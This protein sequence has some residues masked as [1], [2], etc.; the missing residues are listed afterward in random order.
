[1]A[2]L[3]AV[4]KNT[5][6]TAKADRTPNPFKPAFTRT[7]VEDEPTVKADPDEHERFKVQGSTLHSMSRKRLKALEGRTLYS[8]FAPTDAAMRLQRA[9]KMRHTVK[10]WRR[11]PAER[12]EW[13]PRAKQ[14]LRQV[15]RKQAKRNR[16]LAAL[17][18]EM[19]QR[20]TGCGC[21]LA[22]LGPCSGDL[23]MAHGH[24]KGRDITLSLELGNVFPVCEGHHLTGRKNC[25]N[26]D[27]YARG[28]A[29]AADLMLSATKYKRR[30]AP[31]WTELQAEAW[32]VIKR[33]ERRERHAQA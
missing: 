26:H 5:H 12:H 11:S 25:H 32:R 1:M 24:S 31:S 3:Q 17:K 15:S 9:T 10:P 8:T 21:L 22:F 4:P 23:Q 29:A 27:P 33:E 20:W 13:S 16:A 30:E 6:R 7:R 28:L 14:R 2:Q 19:L 18:V